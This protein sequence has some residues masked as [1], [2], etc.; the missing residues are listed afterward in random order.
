[1]VGV[2]FDQPPVLILRYTPT[3][4]I[5]K[6]MAEVYDSLCYKVVRVQ[7]WG[8]KAPKNRKQYKQRR[9]IQ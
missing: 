2:I 5:Q 9:D 8:E 3:F 4:T 1:M 7:R 6:H